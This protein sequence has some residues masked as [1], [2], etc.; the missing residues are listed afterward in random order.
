MKIVY[1]IPNC[2]V[3]GG[4]AIICQHANRLLKRGHDVF[5]VSEKG[6]HRIDWFPNQNVPI[7]TLNQY[8]R[9]VD[10]LVATAWS[11]SFKS[12]DLSAKQKFYFVQSDETRFFEENSINQYFSALTYLLNV[13]YLTEAKWI[14]KWLLE[15]FNHNAALI[16][17]GL[18]KS[19]FYPDNPFA[20][21]GEKTRI[22]LEGAIGIPYKG[23]NE[24]FK[25][26][27]DLDV[28]VWCV[29]SLGKPKPGWHCDRFF[30]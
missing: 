3:S 16:P 23:M 19:I 22:L 4:I 29:S 21:K 12:V 13:N 28:E 11:T 2:D 6:A 8:P 9:G 25:V 20:P 26:I 15:D 24:A 7:L 1:I 17:N 27:E 10:I 5:L 14:K 18:D 30:E